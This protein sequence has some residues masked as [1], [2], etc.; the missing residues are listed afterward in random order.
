MLEY[1]R[2]GGPFHQALVAQFGPNMAGYIRDTMVQAIQS[3]QGPR[4]V[5]RVLA[6]TFGM[7]LTWALRTA[8]TSMLYAYRE[9]TIAGYRRNRH[10]VE[11]WIWHAHLGDHRTCLSCIN[12]H[13][14]RH[15]LDETLNDHHNGRCAMVPATI[16]WESLGVRGV[17][18]PAEIQRGQDWFMGLPASRQ[19]EIMGPSMYDAWQAGRVG[20]DDFSRPY[21]DSVYGEMLRTPSLREL[22]GPEARQYYPH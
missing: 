12:Q 10:V 18:D 17:D 8:R 3:G 6:Q 22:L 7:G 5:G 15:T 19:R 11:G 4:Y 20:W 14:S 1:F 9:A 16:P 21:Q 13:G 2:I